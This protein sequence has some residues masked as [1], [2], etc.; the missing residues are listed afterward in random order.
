MG[1]L[2]AVLAASL[3]PGQSSQARITGR[4]IDPD[5]SAIAGAEVLAINE[6]TGVSTRSRSNE[7]G[8]YVLPFLLPGSYTV[9]ASYT[10]F[11]KYQRKGLVVETAQKLDLDIRLELGSVTEVVEVTA[12]A[13]L[14]ESSS[15]TVSQLLDSRVVTQMPLGNRRALELVRLAANTVWVD[16]SGLAKPLFS[17]AG[18]RTENQMFW[19][20]G[21][22]IQNMRLGVG[23]VD[24]DP[25]VETIREFRVV[26][27]NYSAEFGGSAGGLVVTT[28]KSG[29]NRFRG[30]AFEYFRNDRLDA[31]NFFAPLAGTRKV[32][33]PLRYNLFGA[34]LGGPVVRDKTHFFAGY[35]GTRRTDGDS[36]ILTVPTE[37]QRRGDFSATFQTNGKPLIIYDPATTRTVGG[38]VIRDPFPGNVIPA[39]R[40]DPVARKLV[41]Y[42]PLPN[43]PPVNLAGAQNF[44][45]NRARKFT[46]D[47]V[48][49]RLDHVFS[50]NNRFYF[51]FVY[52]NDPYGWTSN[53]PRREADPQSP[54]DAE[55]DGVPNSV[56]S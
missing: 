30:S 16:Y 51:R 22:N 11:K 18:G 4:V 2:L 6:E 27:N 25:P 34:T 39:D 43:R 31:A 26:Q 47:N 29:T 14:L 32:K 53:Y 8:I 44:A 50:D 28:T 52:N 7:A 49:G 3:A 24:V 33:A 23:Q 37:L 38:R 46:R 17:L 13:P 40:I 56:E 42:W 12:E 48:T 41:S 54:F 36:Q 19:L 1:V 20:D 5:G 45:G 15:A 55:R 35:E 10:G 9:T 21:G